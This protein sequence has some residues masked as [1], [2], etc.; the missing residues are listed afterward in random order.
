MDQ[1]W[2]GVWYGAVNA[3]HRGRSDKFEPFESL[4]G[5]QSMPGNDRA[6]F[7]WKVGLWLEAPP[8]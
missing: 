2:G 1:D 3:A 5:S 7:E 4:I 8:C 6:S